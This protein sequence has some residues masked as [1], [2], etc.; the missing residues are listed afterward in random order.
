[1]MSLLPTLI[2]AGVWYE[3]DVAMEPEEDMEDEEELNSTMQ[4]SYPD[5][6]FEEQAS[7]PTAMD[8]DV[9]NT[10]VAAVQETSGNQTPQAAAAGDETRETSKKDE[11]PAQVG[12]SHMSIVRNSV[13][14]V[15]SLQHALGDCRDKPFHIYDE[16]MEIW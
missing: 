12:K 2:L 1:M 8:T 9:E 15:V 3:Q 7:A 13:L 5:M 16:C 6:R 4:K 10:N 14:T 11:P